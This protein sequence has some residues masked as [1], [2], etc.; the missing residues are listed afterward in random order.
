[1][2]TSGSTVAPDVGRRWSALWEEQP[3]FQPWIE[4]RA[5][6]ALE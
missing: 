5:G 4:S 2:T 3:G 1:M 6:F